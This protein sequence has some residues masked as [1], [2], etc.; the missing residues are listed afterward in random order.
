MWQPWLKGYNGEYS[1]G[2]HNYYAWGMYAWI[3]QDLKKEIAGN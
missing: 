1:A 3:D 2:F